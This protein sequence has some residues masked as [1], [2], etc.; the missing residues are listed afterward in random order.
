M[1]DKTTSLPGVELFYFWI[2]SLAISV[3]DCQ[4]SHGTVILI[5]S[6]LEG[7]SVKVWWSFSLWECSGGNSFST[8]K[9]TLQ[10]D[11]E[12]EDTKLKGKKKIIEEV[13]YCEQFHVTHLTLGSN[14]S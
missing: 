13:V 6:P 5:S 7:I 14:S 12:K 11:S 2:H 4:L 9:V 1:L 3:S 8:A 10:G